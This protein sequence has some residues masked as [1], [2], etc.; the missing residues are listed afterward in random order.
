MAIDS[1]CVAARWRKRRCCCSTQCVTSR[2]QPSSPFPRW[3]S[4]SYHKSVSTLDAALRYCMHRVVDQTCVITRRCLLGRDMAVV[5]ARFPNPLTPNV[6]HLICSM[7]QHGLTM[8]R[9]PRR[10]EG[11]LIAGVPRP[12]M[13]PAAAQ[14]THT[15]YYQV[16]QYNLFLCRAMPLQ[17]ARVVCA[18]F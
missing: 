6:S 15:R 1:F 16:L 9:A 17:W 4:S 2:A 12:F 11:H 3:R 14:H 18:I 13:I 10:Y 7:F 5:P 8:L